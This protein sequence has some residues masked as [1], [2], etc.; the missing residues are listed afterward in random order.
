MFQVSLSTQKKAVSALSALAAI[1][2]AGMASQATAAPIVETL[3]TTQAARLQN[4]VN[5]GNLQ[6]NWQDW[7][8]ANNWLSFG[9][10][11]RGYLD[12][13]V[14]LAAKD[15]VTAATI[16]F[17]KINEGANY[18][19]PDGSHMALALITQDWSG[20]LGPTYPNWGASGPSVGSPIVV[21]IDPDNAQFQ[22]DVTPLFQAW[23]ASPS[24]YFGIRFY[25]TDAAGGIA[26]PNSLNFP[27]HVSG[28]L[29]L[30]TEAVPEP[31]TLGVLA[32]SGLSL[33]GLRRRRK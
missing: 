15:P 8:L 19:I 27:D 3:D 29:V 18:G 24:S 16:K 21:A 32:L 2:A 17:E 28:D 30:T 6:S 1:G 12:W 11:S 31:G 23:Q 10:P 5:Y 22:V 20:Y 25:V 13:G 9:G 7:L 33:L 14:N 26:D 4:S